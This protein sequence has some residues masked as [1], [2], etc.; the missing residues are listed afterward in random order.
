MQ[1]ISS[2]PGLISMRLCCFN[3]STR[4]L[5]CKYASNI[6]ILNSNKNK[7]NVIAYLYVALFLFNMGKYILILKKWLVLMYSCLQ[8]NK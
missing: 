6:Y 4:A 8:L 2:K 7:K 1:K 3:Y 5:D